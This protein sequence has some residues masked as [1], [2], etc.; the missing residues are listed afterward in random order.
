MLRINIVGSGIVGSATGMAFVSHGHRVRFVDTSQSRVTSLLMQ[1]LDAVPPDK[2]DWSDADLTMI[3]VNTPTHDGVIDLSALRAAIRT[4]GFGLAGSDE[5]HVVVV[6]STVPP[7]TTLDIVRPLLED[8]SGRR[9]GDDLGLAMNPEFLRQRS[10]QEDFLRPWLTVFGTVGDREASLLRR[11]YEP[12]GAPMISTDVTTAE[13][14][15]YA[16][17]LYNAT[18]ISFFN[19]FHL[20]CQRLG[21]DSTIVGEAVSRS[22]EG[23][24][25]PGYGIRGGRAYDGA[26][27]PKDTRGFLSFAESLGIDMPLLRATIAVNETM[28]ADERRALDASAAR[29]PVAVR[30]HVESADR[31]RRN[32]ADQTRPVERSMV[33]VSVT[34]A[35]AV[36]REAPRRGI[37]VIHRLGAVMRAAR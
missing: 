5:P 3:S 16:N 4:L 22:A 29:E 23:M 2:A 37:G 19:E 7:G 27:L 10:A 34:S 31:A 26:C 32:G 25:R 6:R 24:W 9:V 36:D 35:I 20:V 28:A 33:P 17:N 15:K 13:I 18:K 8:A 14:I 12:F 21:L 1:G 30:V 11:L